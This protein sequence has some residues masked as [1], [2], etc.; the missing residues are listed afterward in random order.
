QRGRQVAVIGEEVFFLRKLTAVSGSTYR[1]DGLIRARYDTD[2][3]AHAI[4]AKV[5]ICKFDE[6]LALTDPLLTP[7]A[8]L[9]VK[10]QPYA[11]TGLSLASVSAI[12]KTLYGKGLV[13]PPPCGLRVTA[14]AKGVAA[15]RTGQDVTFAWAS[16]LSDP[17]ELGA[18]MH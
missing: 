5:F 9:Y 16:R 11:A 15:Y 1:L 13:P 7:G 2:R 10:A 4:G 17:P 12:N 8:S 14:P 3:Q 6:I 18:G